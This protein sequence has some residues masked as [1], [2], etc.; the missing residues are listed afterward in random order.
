[1][2]AAE[3]RFTP[4]DEEA[5]L[6]E[7]EAPLEFPLRS[8]ALRLKDG[9]F[10]IYSPLKK[11]AAIDATKALGEPQILL[12]PNHFHNLGLAPHVKAFENTRIVA[13]APA[14]KRLQAQTGGLLP[15]PL[16]LLQAQ[17]PN[18]ARILEPPGTKS[19]E[20]W[21]EVDTSKGRIWVICDAFFNVHQAIGGVKGAFLKLIQVT[22]G[23]QIGKTFPWLAL[24]DKN[25]YKKW[26]LE[27]LEEGPPVVLVP[28]HGEILRDKALGD[29]LRTLTQKRL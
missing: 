5:G 4:I 7:L 23:L 28:S 10:L 9:T 13:A 27:R 8:V 21:I 24:K 12:A 15:E 25:A 29:R 19:G 16:S 26:L 1:M 3:F 11:R 18:H 6:F 22:P 2:S 20:T 17:M 14:H